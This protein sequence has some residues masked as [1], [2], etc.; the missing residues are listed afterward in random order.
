MSPVQVASVGL[1]AFWKHRPPCS[2]RARP[3]PVDMGLLALAT[4]CTV[5]ALQP[6]A[7]GARGMARVGRS[8]RPRRRA[9]DRRGEGGKG[10][11]LRFGRGSR[12]A[13]A[14]CHSGAGF[15]GGRWQA[16]TR[17]CDRG[18]SIYEL[19]IRIGP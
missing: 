12:R 13:P 5:L 3:S 2:T 10:L 19:R 14:R 16:K 18:S 11:G 4:P 17:G 6:R 1:A 15:S 8:T 9:V 7:G